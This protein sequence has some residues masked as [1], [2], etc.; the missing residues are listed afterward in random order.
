MKPQVG[1][2]NND[3][4][5]MKCCL[6]AR[7]VSFMM[8]NSMYRPVLIRDINGV[9]ALTFQTWLVHSFTEGLRRQ[10]QEL[11]MSIM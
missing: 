6:N 10:K 2:L 4:M 1:S 11:N 5:P 9:H 3:R 8:V 7:N